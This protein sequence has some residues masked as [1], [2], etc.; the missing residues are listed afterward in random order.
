MVISELLSY[1]SIDAPNP[2]NSIMPFFGLVSY[3]L[4]LHKVC[5]GLSARLREKKSENEQLEELL[6]A[7][8]RGCPFSISCVQLGSFM[9]KNI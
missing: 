4:M 5:A 9:Y 1:R 6:V 8:V 3:T 7:E 2:H